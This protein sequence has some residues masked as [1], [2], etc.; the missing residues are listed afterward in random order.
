MLEVYSDLRSSHQENAHLL[1]REQ[2]NQGVD[3]TAISDIA[4]FEDAPNCN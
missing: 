3:F 4:R 1:E 2:H